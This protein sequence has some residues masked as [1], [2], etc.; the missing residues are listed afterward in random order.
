MAYF[1]GDGFDLYTQ[2]TDCGSYWDGTFGSSVSLG[3]STTGRFAGSRSLTG[4]LSLATPYITKTSGTNDAVHHL[5]LALQQTN[6]LAGATSCIF[7]TL[8]DGATAQ[9]TVIFRQDGTLLLQAGGAGGTT[10]AT[11]VGALTAINTWYQ[12][13]IEIVINNTTGS[14]TVRKNGNTSN[15][16]TATGLNTRVSA[17]NY[18]NK[19]GLGCGNSTAFQFIDDFL[20][21]SDAASVPWLGDIRCSTRMPAADVAVQFSP[22]NAVG[23]PQTPYVN[24]IGYV[25]SA[26]QARYSSFIAMRTGTVSTITIPI[27]VASTANLKC[28]IFSSNGGAPGTV[29]GSA[30]PVNLTGLLVAQSAT[31]TFST[32]VSVTSGTQ[33]FVGIIADA[34]VG[35]V[36]ANSTAI[37]YFLSSATYATFPTSNPAVSSN[38]GGG[39]VFTV[40]I[41]GAG[42]SPFVA[43]AQQDALA[44][45]VSDGTVG[46]ADLYSIGSITSTPLN[47]IAVVTRGYCQKNDAGTRILAV[48][49]KSGATTV[50][51]AGSVLAVGTWGWE[52]RTDLT[53]PAT[54]A[55]WTGA[56][57]NNVQIGPYLVA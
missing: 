5:S 27:V 22:S 1:F 6:A 14:I 3:I 10:L 4:L 48:R 53:D 12:F 37:N 21:R 16:F 36:G 55:A 51:S 8:T 17:N 50:Q 39:H 28:T 43:E 11:Y 34:N 29:L 52:W 54:G 35:Q 19:I 30:T 44:T 24:N 20:W 49:L 23:Y 25:L 45:Y 42:N 47:V 41:A 40:I 9:C 13:E 7:F 57:V 2:L 46:H 31:L 15:D 26:N 33:Y 38:V 18:A 32:P 56:A